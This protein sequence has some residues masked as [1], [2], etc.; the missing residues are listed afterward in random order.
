V[1]AALA[2]NC[3]RMDVDVVDVGGGL[4]MIRLH[5]FTSCGLHLV[6]PVGPMPATAV[7]PW[8]EEFCADVALSHGRDLVLHAGPPPDP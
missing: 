3:E 5:Y 2:F 1:T 8:L 4:R 7:D 6:E